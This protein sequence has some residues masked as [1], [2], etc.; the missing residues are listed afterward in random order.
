MEGGVL[1]SIE[2]VARSIEEHPVRAKNN[3]I[4]IKRTKPWLPHA[5]GTSTVREKYCWLF[6][7]WP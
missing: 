3:V 6:F 5:T 1:G 2:L 7:T 4:M